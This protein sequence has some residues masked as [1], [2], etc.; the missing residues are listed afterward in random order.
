MM[1]TS[2]Q[3]YAYIS[4]QTYDLALALYVLGVAIISMMYDKVIRCVA[5]YP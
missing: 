3:C 1:D 4:I 2:A 5:I